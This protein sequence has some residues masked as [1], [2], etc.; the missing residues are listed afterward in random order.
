MT[1]AKRKFII[2]VTF[3][4]LSGFL[5]LLFPLVESESLHQKEYSPSQFSLETFNKNMNVTTFASPD[6]SKDTLSH[7]L[8]HAQ[9]SIYV[10]IYGIDN[11][12]ILDIL[13]EI[14]TSNPTIDMKFL[15]GYNSLDYYSS[16]DYVANNLTLL[17]YPV[18]WTSD[19]E[20]TY[21][22]QKFVI[23]D[24]KTT[25]VHSGNWAKTS[26]PEDGMDANR[27]WSIA[28][29]DT[30][31]TDYYRSVFDY[32]W[33]NGVDYNAGTDGTGTA[34]SYIETSSTYPRPFASPGHFSGPMNVTPIVG[35][36]TG[37]QGI[38]YCINAA[39]VTLDIQIPYF[40]N[41]LDGGSVDT[42]VNAIIAAKE[43]GV[44]VR[45]ISEEDYDYLEIASLF[46]NNSIPIVWQD[47]RWCAANH[48]KGIIVD[49][50]IVLISSINF[51]DNSIENNRE[52]G[53]II[54]H[55]GV[56]Q[57]YLEVFDYD[58]GMADFSNIGDVNVYWDP[59][60]PNSSTLINVTVFGH[61]LYDSGITGVYLSVKIDD[62][63]WTN[64]SIIAND[65]ESAEGDPENYFYVLPAQADT[66]N[67][68][69][70][71]YVFVGGSGYVSDPI[72]IRVRDSIPAV[73]PPTTFTTPTIII[74]PPPIDLVEII[75]N[76]IPIA[77]GGV[78]VVIAGYA[79]Q[80]TVNKAKTFRE[81]FGGYQPLLTTEQLSVRSDF[82]EPT[83]SK[84][85]LSLQ[86]QLSFLGIGIASALSIYVGECIRRKQDDYR[87]KIMERRISE[88]DFI[89]Q[90][91]QKLGFVAEYLAKY[92]WADVAKKFGDFKEGMSANEVYQKINSL[93][94]TLCDTIWKNLRIIELPDT[95]ESPPAIKSLREDVEE[96][97]KPKSYNIELQLY[98][99]NPD[100]F[101]E[102]KEHLKK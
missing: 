25:I 49:G 9:E 41:Y 79:A 39:Q 75:S 101:E 46:K 36:D 8:T 60:I 26:F 88:I 91:H 6:G 77:F 87:N 65:Y 48:N 68:T 43:R 62:G 54:E 14:H 42:I 81:L 71:A 99:E 51:G 97:F 12:Y 45:V 31:V 47:T 10:E 82:L 7:F 58:W 19:S 22:H 38:L 23:I 27:E 1:G 93:D 20:F 37:I 33:G 83:I 29:T 40:T 5:C 61:E 96:K 52:V 35:P 78:L 74:L 4:V 100:K 24:N 21:A 2:L 50:R 76:L 102:S 98:D 15:L 80:A 86:G 89:N 3:L 30:D 44:T 53:V 70:K 57:W 84:V 95:K 34:P 92:D 63:I 69:V 90:I 55:E 17:G 67:I 28:M 56:A 16:N 72:V 66:T 13:H 18:K 94:T 85:E 59:N 11:P 73:L 32:D 64:Y